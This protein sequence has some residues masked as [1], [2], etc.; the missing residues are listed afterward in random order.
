MSFAA[1]GRGDNAGCEESFGFGTS[2]AFTV[3]KTRQDICPQWSITQIQDFSIVLTSS[4]IIITDAQSRDG[5]A[6]SCVPSSLLSFLSVPA[7]SPIAHGPAI[8]KSL[9]AFQPPP[10]FSHPFCCP[11]MLWGSCRQEPKAGPSH[12]S[13]A[14]HGDHLPWPNEGLHA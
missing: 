2:T 10:A 5:H 6:Q 4:A 14:G 13:K 12:L 3:Y 8:H 11:W 1:D 7:L 9:S